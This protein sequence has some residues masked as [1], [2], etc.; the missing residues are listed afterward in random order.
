[1]ILGTSV[2]GY[3]MGTTTAIL[4][5]Q[6]GAEASMNNKMQ[7][8]N[9]YM[10]ERNLPHHLAVRVRKHF[11]YVWARALIS[12]EDEG[13]L[14][15]ALSF[16]LRE[17][18]L[19]FIYKSTVE[20]MPLFQRW[21]EAKDGFLEM[22]LREIHPL[23]CTNDDVI[24][25]QGRPATE[26]FFITTGNV[27][28]LHHPANSHIHNHHLSNH[29]IDIRHRT[30]M[31]L[32]KVEAGSYFGEIAI[33][34]KCLPFI[35][36]EDTESTFGQV[37]R[38]QSRRSKHEMVK[39]SLAARIKVVA[40]AA[41]GSEAAQ[42]L[43]DARMA[44]TLLLQGEAAFLR[45]ASVR[46]CGEVELL[47]LSDTKLVELMTIFPRI[48]LEVHAKARARLAHTVEMVANRPKVDS[49]T[50]VTETKTRSR[51]LWNRARAS[52]VDE[53]ASR[54]KAE[55]DR[56]QVPGADTGSAR[57]GRADDALSV[58]PES[59]PVTRDAHERWAQ[60]I[61]ST[62]ASGANNAFVANIIDDFERKQ[63]AQLQA[64]RSALCD[65][66]PNPSQ[67]A[68]LPP[69]LAAQ[70]PSAALPDDGSGFDSFSQGTADSPSKRHTTL[71]RAAGDGVS[72]PATVGECGVYEEVSTVPTPQE[73]SARPSD[74]L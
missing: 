71:R 22:L 14:L 34:D 36:A 20:L 63:K 21:A 67:A 56:I 18:V 54:K 64:L 26:M 58:T 24:V 74:W 6:Q 62:N 52:H 60:E 53:S 50:E 35:I 41:Q 2:F 25:E 69:K 15:N 70:G 55:A 66:L 10:H 51:G 32:G 7:A 29:G 43:L 57:P 28:I 23:F 31:E 40:S 72:A 39:E 4:T 37:E 1:M 9:S 46:A 42:Q 19:N 12:S 49:G 73:V 13:N 3:V 59:P 5:M 16:G 44:D 30:F 61:L 33:L 11:R 8:L 47:T 48:R 68:V 65:F 17:D 45:T 27:R 38:S